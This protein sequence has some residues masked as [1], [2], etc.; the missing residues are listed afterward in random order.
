MAKLG[1][2]V[3]AG[4][5]AFAASP[6]QTR[7]AYDLTLKNGFTIHHLRHEV[8]GA[9]TR[10]YLDGTNFIDV[11]SADIASITES[12]ESGPVAPE[13]Q[14]KPLDINQVVSAASDKHQI[15]RDLITSVIHAESSFNP[16]AKSPKGA[17][18]LMQLMPGTASRLGVADAFDPSANVDGGT[19]YLRE[20]L[21]QYHGDMVK[22]LAAYNAG[23][24]RVQQYN[25][26]PPYRETRAYVAKVVKE[27]NRKKL[28]ENAKPRSS[29]SKPAQRASKSDAAD[30]N[31]HR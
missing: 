26:V 25:G 18:G 1:V 16:H 28:A 12:Q 29:D 11:P 6:G 22:A 15:D 7:T 21:L 2:V 8:I 5:S 30:P 17:Q 20:L 9:N 27:F 4:A 10:L 14:N 19:K 13:L 24:Q 31:Q 3:L 23:P